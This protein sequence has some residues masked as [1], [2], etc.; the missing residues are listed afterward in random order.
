M[1][2]MHLVKKAKMITRLV[3]C[4]GSSPGHVVLVGAEAVQVMVQV[5]AGAPAVAVE[6][7]ATIMM[8]MR[9]IHHR[10]FRILLRVQL[11]ASRSSVTTATVAFSIPEDGCAHL[12]TRAAMTPA[13]KSDT[14]SNGE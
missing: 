11:V 4:K 1:T 10:A 7:M 14:A 5:G 2:S 13:R 3:T 9:H 12:R 8:A 6:A